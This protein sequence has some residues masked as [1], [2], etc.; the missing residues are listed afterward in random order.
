MNVGANFIIIVLVGCT[1]GTHVFKEQCC[2]KI[3]TLNFSC[4]KYFLKIY[5]YG[6]TSNEIS[7]VVKI[8]RIFEIRKSILW[9][10]VNGM[11]KVV[12]NTCR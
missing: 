6:K 3:T 12:Q 9:K 10:L 8:D 1:C 11:Y 7:I 4:N 5:I 2:E